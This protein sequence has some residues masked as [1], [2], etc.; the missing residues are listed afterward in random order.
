[1]NQQRC[2][3]RHRRHCTYN[4]ER[5]QTKFI[6]Q[7]ADG[8]HMVHTDKQV[9]AAERTNH[10]YAVWLEPAT[11]A[12]YFCCASL[13]S[14]DSTTPSWARDAW[15]KMPTAKVS[16]VMNRNPRPGIFRTVVVTS[17]KPVFLLSGTLD[18][19]QLQWC[20]DFQQVEHE[21]VAVLDAAPT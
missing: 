8:R 3:F 2:L 6:N 10:E 11:I 16:V 20:V 14:P 13:P 19:N 9:Q 7:D 18:T 4:H 17:A 21:R 15:R 12:E 5:Q 1:M